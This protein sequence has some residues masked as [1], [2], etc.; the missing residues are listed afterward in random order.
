MIDTAL[1]ILVVFGKKKK[2][3]LIEIQNTNSKIHTHSCNWSKSGHFHR[4]KVGHIQVVVLGVM[5]VAPYVYMYILHVCAVQ[6][7]QHHIE[8]MAGSHF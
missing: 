2:I 4:R 3:H 6:Q 5:V 1:C 7:Y 8:N